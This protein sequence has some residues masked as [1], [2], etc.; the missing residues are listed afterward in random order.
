M[1]KYY[2]YKNECCT[3]KATCWVYTSK[4]KAIRENSQ[5]DNQNK[6]DGDCQI[7]TRKKDVPS[8]VKEF[9]NAN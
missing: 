6:L 1:K 2:V 3:V 4:R 7:V 8:Y 9:Y 5:C